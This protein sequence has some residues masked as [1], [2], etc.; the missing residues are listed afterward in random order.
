MTHSNSVKSAT[1]MAS[2][3]AFARAWIVSLSLILGL[4]LALP[5]AMAQEDAWEELSISGV[6]AFNRGDLVEAADKFSQALVI[7]RGFEHSDQ[8]LISSLS[9]LGMAYRRLELF[10]NAEPLFQEAIRVQQATLGADHPDL[11]ATLSS[12]ADLYMVQERW[13][14]ARVLLVH[15][16]EIR[17]LSAGPDHPYTALVVNS[18]WEISLAV[19]NWAD[20][21]A[22]FGRVVSIRQQNFGPE[23]RSLAYPL[24][25]LG[26]ALHV[27]G[28]L[29]GAA[30]AFTH[31][32]A[33]WDTVPAP[34]SP[35][36]LLTLESAAALFRETGE[37]ERA[38]GLESVAA[39]IRGD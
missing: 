30:G 25:R 1:F 15:A 38:A 26:I 28:D 8:R 27:L 2:G 3:S 16:L 6:E 31:A 32:L 9:N 33:V 11:S 39:I 20:A 35:E 22:L 24:T 4:F 37:N 17:E 10:D 13:D 5:L 21:G 14:E 29:E 18:L 36:Y 19:E 7:A 12:L 34:V 23:H